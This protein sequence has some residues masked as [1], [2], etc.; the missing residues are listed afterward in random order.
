MN[1]INDL[2]GMYKT[3]T[4]AQLQEEIDAVFDIIWAILEVTE[5]DKI[6]SFPN[7]NVKLSFK[8]EVIKDE[9]RYYC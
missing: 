6:E 2:I 4:D 3:M 5:S 7:P 8:C 9:S 1:K